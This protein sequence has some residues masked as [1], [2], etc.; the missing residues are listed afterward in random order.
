MRT[1]RCNSPYIMA[2]VTAAAVVVVVV[3]AVVMVG[4]GGTYVML[5]QRQQ[6]VGQQDCV[7]AVHIWVETVVS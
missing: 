6:T 4:G 7:A 3:V 1:T 5:L 2:N